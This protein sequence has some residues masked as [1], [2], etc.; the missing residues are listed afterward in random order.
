MYIR[1]KQELI[2]RHTF[3]KCLML[4]E[5]SV[6]MRLSEICLISKMCTTGKDYWLF[7][8]RQKTQVNNVN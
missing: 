2:S 6:T 7:S 8:R 5:K 4:V 1:F 3:F